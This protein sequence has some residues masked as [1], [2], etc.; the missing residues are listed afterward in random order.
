MSQSSVSRLLSSSPRTDLQRTASSD[1][2]STMAEKKTEIHR[3]Y[4]RSGSA[5]MDCFFRPQGVL[6]KPHD[7]LFMKSWHVRS[8]FKDLFVLSIHK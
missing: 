5:Q 1:D 6:L 7:V 4:S 3:F 2:G 8:F